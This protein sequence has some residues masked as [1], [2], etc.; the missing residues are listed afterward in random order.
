MCTSFREEFKKGV[1][2]YAYTEGKFRYDSGIFAT[3]VVKKYAF[4]VDTF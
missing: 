2:P 4:M 3:V 1:L